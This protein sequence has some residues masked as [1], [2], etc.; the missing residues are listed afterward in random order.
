MLAAECL[1]RPCCTALAGMLG[2]VLVAGVVCCCACVLVWS[3]LVALV[4]LLLTS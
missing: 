2:V 4:L 1:E 3:V